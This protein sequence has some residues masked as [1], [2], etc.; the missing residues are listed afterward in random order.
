MYKE[1]YSMYKENISML[2]ESHSHNT[3]VK[4]QMQRKD[5][6]LSGTFLVDSVQ[7]LGDGRLL[8]S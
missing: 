6:W 8:S 7:L 5:T 1:L 3:S 2:E 4:V